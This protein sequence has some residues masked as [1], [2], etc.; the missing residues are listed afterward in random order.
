M[1]SKGL[2]LLAPT[3]K[4]RVGE[5]QLI[6]VSVSLRRRRWRGCGEGTTDS[7][8][9]HLGPEEEEQDWE[10]LEVLEELEE[11]EGRE[12]EQEEEKLD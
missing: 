4:Q 2:S 12:K 6:E 11:L 7:A 1:G 5:R 10:V 3:R 8:R 9:T